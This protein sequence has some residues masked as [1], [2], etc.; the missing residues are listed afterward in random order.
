MLELLASRYKNLPIYIVLDNARYQ[1]CDFVKEKASKLNISLI[2]LPPYSPNLNLIERV[3]KYVK[4]EYLRNQY[5]EDA[6]TFHKAIKNAMINLNENK[7]IRHELK[8][9]L[10]PKFQ[11]FA[12]NLMA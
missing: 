5:F 8:I 10:N 1:H 6:A 12:Q 9:L 7:S 2:F 11:S 4:K 3:W